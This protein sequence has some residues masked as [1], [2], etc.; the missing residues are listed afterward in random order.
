MALMMPSAWPRSE[1]GNE[2]VITA[3]PVGMT[4]EAPMAWR[5]RAATSSVSDPAMAASVRAMVK[6]ANPRP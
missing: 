3:A 6:I 4:I 1:A 2:A 5:T